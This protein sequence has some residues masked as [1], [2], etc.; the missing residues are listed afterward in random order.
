M[1]RSAA[2]VQSVGRSALMGRNVRAIAGVLPMS[3]VP[4]EPNLGVRP[5]AEEPKW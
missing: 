4:Y 2:L 1:A 5:V 3:K